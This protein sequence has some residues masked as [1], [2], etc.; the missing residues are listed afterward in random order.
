VWEAALKD[1]A[2]LKALKDVMAKRSRRGRRTP[3]PV[4][5]SGLDRYDFADLV[6]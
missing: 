4:K 3:D 6:P 2:S 1:R 5:T